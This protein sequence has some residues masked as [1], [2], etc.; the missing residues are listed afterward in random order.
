MTRSLALFA[1]LALVG[2]T[3]ASA[4]VITR[5]A[6]TKGYLLTLDVG[7]TEAMYTAA[8][9]KAKHP[10]GGE[11]MVGGAMMAGPMSAMEGATERHLELHIRKRPG[12]AVV[13]TVMPAITLTDTTAKSMPEKV[14]VVAMKGIGAGM[15]DLHYGNNVSLQP[16]H[17][18]RVTVVVHGQTATFTFKAA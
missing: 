10:T 4:A 17:T 5:Q 3:A 9:A 12:G 14:E 8:Q 6:T 13:T 7:P 16:G 15:A 2:V 11:L 1:A 18:Y